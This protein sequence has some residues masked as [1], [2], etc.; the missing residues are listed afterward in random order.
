MIHVEWYDSTRA[1]IHGLE[2]NAF[3][4][5]DYNPLAV[6]GGTLMQLLVQVWPFAALLATSGAAQMINL[7]IVLLILTLCW[8]N[9][10]AYGSKYWYGIGFPVCTLFFLYI[11]WR[12]M[13]VV[14]G[15]GGIIWRGT[16]YPLTQ[17]K[18]NKI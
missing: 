11:L 18:A 3:A 16:L 15:R 5:L 10:R 7:L 1:L 2:K 12:T 9:A 4:G 13:L 17:L 14:L 6:L 8:D